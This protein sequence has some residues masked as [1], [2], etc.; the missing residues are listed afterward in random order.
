MFLDKS[1]QQQKSFS[2]LR[3]NGDT[4]GMQIAIFTFAK[5][6]TEVI[7]RSRKQDTICSKWNGM[8]ENNVDVMVKEAFLFMW[9]VYSKHFPFFKETLP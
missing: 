6:L 3:K 8:F 7:A 1:L 2:S 5:Y 9:T 4:M